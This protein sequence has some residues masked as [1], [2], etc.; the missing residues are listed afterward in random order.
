MD[1]LLKFLAPYHFPI[2]GFD[3]N[4]SKEILIGT[5]II[6]CIEDRYFIVTASHVMNERQ[7]VKHKELWLWNYHDGSKYTITEDIVGD[8]QLDVPHSHDVAIIEIDIKDYKTLDHHE[9]YDNCFLGLER[10]VLDLRACDPGAEVVYLISGFPC[11]KNKNLTKK[12]H[13]QAFFTREVSKAADSALDDLATVSLEWDSKQLVE[14][15]MALP[16]PQGMSGGGVWA[17]TKDHEF[18]PRLFAISVA[19]IKRENK[20]IAVKMAVVLAILQAFFP[21]TKL[22]DMDMPVLVWAGEQ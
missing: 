10:M 1:E 14:K 15:G 18:S 9:F 12:P 4:S 22:D 16:A 3:A 13:M 19:Y 5:C 7:N 6:I 2:L 8:D 11:S 17:L 21:G 20:V